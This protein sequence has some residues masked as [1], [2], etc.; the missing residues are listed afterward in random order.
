MDLGD[1]LI[2]PGKEL[3]NCPRDELGQQIIF[4]RG[5]IS[6][7]FLNKGD[8]I[9]LGLP[10]FDKNQ[11]VYDD[12]CTWI[13]KELYLLSS[14]DL[15][16]AGLVDLGNLKPGNDLKET[17]WLLQSLIGILRE[18]GVFI[19]LI[20]GSGILN[21]GILKSFENIRNDYSYT[22][23]EPRFSLV[24][25]RE[26]ELID[27]NKLNYYNLGSQSCFLTE[28][29]QAWIKDL[30]YGTCRLGKIRSDLQEAE[31]YIRNSHGCSISID[32]VKYSDAPGQKDATPNGFYSEEVCQL[33]RYAGMAGGLEIFALMDYYP[34]HDQH[35]VTA[36][37]LA[38]ILWYSME[39]YLLRIQEHPYLDPHFRKFRVSY[40]PHQITF[41]KSDRTARW[42]MEV[43]LKGSKKNGVFPC[44][45]S[46]YELACQKELPERW[47]FYYQKLNL[48]D[49]K[50]GLA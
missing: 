23:V 3:I 40:D 42:W 35:M 29:Q 43:T 4:N 39:G 45:Q 17:L 34:G 36:K 47:L 1:Y 26:F 49:D 8:L 32:S 27:F 24:D 20:G 16:K 9:M 50:N 28:V 46:D 13:R 30:H 2:P 6:V 18:S 37:L 22:I 11:V 31:P 19:L 25:Y 44:N 14:V 15:G 5:D 21:L 38:Q 41:Y 7:D 33:A 48:T 12:S 10:G